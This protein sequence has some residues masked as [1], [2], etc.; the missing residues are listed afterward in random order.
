[1][2]GNVPFHGPLIELSKW[3]LYNEG[4]SPVLPFV[5]LTAGQKKLLMSAVQVQRVVS[6]Y[7]A[8]LHEARLTEFLYA[9][10]RSDA[11]TMRHVSETWPYLSL[12][13]N[14]YSNSTD[15]S[16]LSFPHLHVHT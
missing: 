5:D 10:S 13:T 8:K 11:P 6:S 15:I 3:V 1:M 4:L 9:V 2:V 14:S 7:K 12:G 16:T